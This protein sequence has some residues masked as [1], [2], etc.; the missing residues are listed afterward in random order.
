[1]KSSLLKSR[2]FLIMVVNVV[3]SVT[4]YFI[5]KYFNPDAAKD[6]LFLI[7]SL[8]PVIIAVVASITVQNVEY[9]KAASTAA[10]TKAFVTNT[11]PEQEL[12]Q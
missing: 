8:Q 2:K 3:V 12:P 11:V 1:M 5:T 10:E 9:I 7:G 4:T 6:V